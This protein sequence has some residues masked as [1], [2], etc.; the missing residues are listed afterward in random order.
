MSE[1]EA[2]AERDAGPR[3]EFS[4]GMAAMAPL[5]L[6]V[7]PFGV[8]FGMLAG[9][10]GLSGLATM[11]MSAL[12]FA[13]SAQFVAVGLLGQGVGYPLIVLSTLILN[14][15][16][17]LYGM[18]LGPHLKGVGRRLHA[19]LAFGLADEAFAV[20]IVRARQN[21]GARHKEWHTLGAESALYISWL[22]S[23]GAGILLGGRITDPLAWGLD[24]ALPV[25]FIGLLVPLVQ[26]RA[27]LAAVAVSAALVMVAAPL[28]RGLNIVV[29]TLGGVVA[30]M[31]A[32]R[33]RRWR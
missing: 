13:G 24:F 26:G 33:W 11:A 4:T 28:P 18:A 19:A 16:H 27:G 21:D 20:A 22:C 30:G 10:V 5:L 29:A 9:Q 2:Q 15:R 32:E 23:T 25:T 1:E 7:I 6:G 3:G 14:L 8:V 17:V 31:A 12:V